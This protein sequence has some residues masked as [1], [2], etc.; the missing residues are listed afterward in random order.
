M[1]WA[2]LATVTRTDTSQEDMREAGRRVRLPMRQ[3]R[4]GKLGEKLPDY[5]PPVSIPAVWL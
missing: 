2:T 5:Y 3:R 4:M 1:R